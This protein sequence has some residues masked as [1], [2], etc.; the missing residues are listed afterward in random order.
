MFLCD[1]RRNRNVGT[2]R[3]LSLSSR[4]LIQVA[5]LFHHLAQSPRIFSPVSAAPFLCPCSPVVSSSH[6]ISPA[7]RADQ[8]V[9]REPILMR[10]H[11]SFNPKK[12]PKHLLSSGDL[13]TTSRQ[14]TLPLPLQVLGTLTRSQAL[15]I[16]M[17]ARISGCQ[18][19]KARE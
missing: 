16:W 12:L 18:I 2:N 13:N 9:L 11:E 1:T 6:A 4:A 17:T 7:G 15:V 10:C 14:Q 3:K 5:S 19:K 8:L